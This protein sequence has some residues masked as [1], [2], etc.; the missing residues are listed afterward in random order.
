MKTFVLVGLMFVSV[1]LPVGVR[2]QLPATTPEIAIP[3][4]GTLVTEINLSENDLLGVIKQAIPAFTQSAAGATGEIGQLIKNIDLNTFVE[5]IQGVRHIR[6]M[7]FKLSS[8]AAP[9]T[10]LRFY[11]NRLAAE[12]NSAWTRTLF[13]ASSPEKG[14]VMVLTKGGQEYFGVATDT[15]ESRVFVIRTVGSVDMVKLAAWAG[16]TAKLIS[17]MKSKKEAQPVPK[18]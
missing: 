2:A 4:G 10:I 11:E 9:S 12:E 6:A 17:E 15:K 7:Q 14:Q 5:A 18:K 13:D 16:Q 3:P 8:G 1:G